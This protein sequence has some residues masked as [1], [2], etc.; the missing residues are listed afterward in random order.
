[1]TRSLRHV[2]ILPLLECFVQS[3]SSSSNSGGCGLSQLWR[4]Y[5][6]I[7]FGSCR[8]ILDCIEAY[9]SPPPPRSTTASNQIVHSP[10]SLAELD[11][12]TLVDRA[13]EQK[14][15]CFNEQSLQPITK[16][17]LAALDYLHSRHVIH[18]RVE[19][20]SV[21]ISVTGHV[22]LGRVDSAVSLIAQGT[23]AKRLH[24]FPHS[25]LSL[26]YV[27]PEILQQVNHYLRGDIFLIR[28]NFKFFLLEP[29]WL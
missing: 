20:E 21:F 23:L 13:D 25:K 9:Y 19:P 1:M 7:Y 8:D 28:V 5:P 6:H 16:S 18:R 22:Y 12:D 10:S 17:L 4:D 15:L 2:N 27:A 11:E 26:D 29:H 14:R 3:P 24:D